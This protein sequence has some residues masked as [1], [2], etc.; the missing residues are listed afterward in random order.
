MSGRISN[1]NLQLFVW[2]VRLSIN[3][4]VAA[5]KCFAASQYAGPDF[6]RLLACSASP[7]NVRLSNQGLK[8]VDAESEQPPKKLCLPDL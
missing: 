1:A 3:L 7:N 2:S 6:D 8:V 4:D 5:G